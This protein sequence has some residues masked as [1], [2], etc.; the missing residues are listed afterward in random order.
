MRAPW[1]T[2][3]PTAPQPITATRAPSQTFAVSST[4][5]TPVATAQPIRH[6]CSTG[7]SRGTFTAATSGTTVWVANVPVRS[8]GVSTLPS[9]RN[10]RPAAAGGRLH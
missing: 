2:D 6:A 4:D 7:S 1:I 10:S 8:T 9:R 5:M 3:S